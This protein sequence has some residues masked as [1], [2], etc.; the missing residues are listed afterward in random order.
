MALEL[1]PQIHY[2]EDAAVDQ[3]LDRKIRAIL[4]KCFSHEPKFMAQRYNNDPPK[5]RWYIE[6]NDGIIAHLAVHEKKLMINSAK[7]DF[8]GIAEVCVVPEF[9]G[10]KFV[11][12]LLSQAEEFLPQFKYA[13]LLGN[14]DFYRSSGFFPVP[15][16]YFWQ[17]PES[18]AEQALVKCFHENKW[19]NNDRGLTI[20]KSPS[21]PNNPN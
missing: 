5:H 11:S 12:L 8:M 16:I 19:P 15:N 3:I 14:S 13:I 1:K 10:L 21:S 9:R 4:V 2:I 7:I 20:L 6:W 18:A 17:Q